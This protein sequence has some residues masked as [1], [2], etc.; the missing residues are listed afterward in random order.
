MIDS[1][2]E[3]TLI[4][5]SHRTAPVAVREQF[6]VQQSDLSAAHES[7]IAVSEI[8]EVFILST[9][10]RTEVLLATQKGFDPTQEATSRVFRNLDSDHLYSFRNIEAVIHLFRV[11]AGLD[12]MVLGESEVL[13]QV[14]RSHEIASSVDSVGETLEPLIRAA[15]SA[16]KRVRTETALGQ[17]TL[18]VAR[19]GVDIAKRVFGT[20]EQRNATIVGAGETGMLVARHLKSLGIRHLT[21]VNRTFERAQEAAEEFDAIAWRLEDIGSAIP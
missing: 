3:F 16:G 1:S 11:S 18:S 2:L 20:F 7:L 8:E 19:V 13:A 14:K 21:F 4:G 9:C 6:V 12:S 10:N 17:G 15:I 5:F